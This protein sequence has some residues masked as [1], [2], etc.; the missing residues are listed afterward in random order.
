MDILCNNNS[1]LKRKAN[2]EPQ[3]CKADPADRGTPISTDTHQH[4]ARSCLQETR[5]SSR[6]VA[7]AD[8]PEENEVALVV[9]R[10]HP[11]APELRVLMEQAAQHA[12]H[13]TPQ[14]RV[15]VVQ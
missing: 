3:N 7:Q 12:P 14:A 1:S 2:T 5:A 8:P 4:T 9:E 15:E 11:P 10:D 13:A 6:C